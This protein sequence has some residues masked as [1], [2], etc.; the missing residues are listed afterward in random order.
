MKELALKHRTGA[1]RDRLVERAEP[2]HIHEVPTIRPSGFWNAPALVRTDRSL[3]RT[4]IRPGT[5]D[6][7]R[8]D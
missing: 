8:E 3:A 7:D 6:L 4:R 5:R 2:S 1:R